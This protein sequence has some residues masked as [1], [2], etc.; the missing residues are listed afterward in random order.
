M[1][2]YCGTWQDRHLL[3]FRLELL[4]RSTGACG[5]GWQLAQLCTV[6]PW[7]S[8]WQSRQSGRYPC[9]TWQKVQ[10]RGACIPF[11]FASASHCGAWQSTH[12]AFCNCGYARPCV[13]GGPSSCTGGVRSVHPLAS[14]HRSIPMIIIVPVMCSRFAV[15]NVSGCDC[16]RDMVLLLLLCLL[17]F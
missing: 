15:M 11:P 1:P 10:F 13:A 4:I 2:S 3:L 9:C 16:A 14:T 5:F 17:S 6:A 7:V 8:G 12:S